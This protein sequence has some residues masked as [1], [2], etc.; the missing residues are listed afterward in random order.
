MNPCQFPKTPK[1]LQKKYSGHDLSMPCMYSMCMFMYAVGAQQEIAA[2]TLINDERNIGVT[3]H[4]DN[5]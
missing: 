2:E 3:E 1:N 4:D 5:L